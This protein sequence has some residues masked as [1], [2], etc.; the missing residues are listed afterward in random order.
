MSGRDTTTLLIAMKW[1]KRRLLGSL[2]CQR[3]SQ[4]RSI[5]EL[6]CPSLQC[7]HERRHRNLSYWDSQLRCQNGQPNVKQAISCLSCQDNSWNMIARAV[8]DRERCK[9]LTDNCGHLQQVNLRFIFE[10]SCNQSIKSCSSQKRIEPRKVPI[11][12]HALVSV[13]CRPLW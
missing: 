2:L 9:A 12:N 5:F 1:R 10:G 13:L 4:G 8:S 7:Q 3:T 11:H 6:T